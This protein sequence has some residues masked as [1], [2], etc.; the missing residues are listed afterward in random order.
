MEVFSQSVIDGNY[1]DWLSVETNL[2]FLLGLFPEY[3]PLFL[4]CIDGTKSMKYYSHSSMNLEAAILIG[5]ESPMDIT[6]HDASIVF[7]K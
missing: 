3:Q 4:A 6:S 2:E 7:A 1:R 5:D